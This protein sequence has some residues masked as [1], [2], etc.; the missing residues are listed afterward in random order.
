M[1]NVLFKTSLLLTLCGASVYLNCE[2]D[3]NWV[4]VSPARNV[5]FEPDLLHLDTAFVGGSPAE[6]VAG[7]RDTYPKEGGVVYDSL[8]GNCPGDVSWE[9]S[10]GIIPDG[11]TLPITFRFRP[12]SPLDPTT[13]RLRFF[14]AGALTDFGVILEIR[15]AAEE[16]ACSLTPG[17]ELNFGDV[18]VGTESSL[19]LNLQ[20][21]TSRPTDANRL[22]YEFGAASGDCGP[23]PLNPSDSV[24]VIGPDETKSI[25]FVFS[26]SGLE[27]FECRRPLISR[28]V[29]DDP[30]LDEL[31]QPCPGEII[32]RGSGTRP[33]FYWESCPPG[34]NIDWYGVHGLSASEVYVAG[35]GGSVLVSGGDCQWSPVSPFIIDVNLKGIWGSGA[36][37]QKALWSVG[38]IP[39]PQGTFVQSGAILRWANGSWTKV[40]EGLMD[41]YWSVWGSGPDDVYF[42]GLGV[43]TD[44]PNAKHWIGSGDTL[45]VLTISDLGMS[46]VSGLSGTGPNDVWAV[47]E[48]T[49]YSVYRF[50]GGEGW[51]NQTQAFVN[52]AL[53]DVWAI[54][55]DAFYAVYAVG[56]E[57]SVYRYYGEGA[58]PEPIWSDESIP[59]ETRD[60]FGVWIS[61]TGQVFVVGEG[62]VIYRGHVNDPGN[63]T[64]NTAPPDLTAG[65]L[66]DVW[67][68]GDGD[69]YAVGTNGVIIRY[70]PAG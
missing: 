58:N 18:D 23:F 46:K 8:S 14:G 37:D 57:G 70:T 69:V 6:G 9:P 52:Q 21:I 42:G 25:Q 56:N 66:M 1:R 24:G 38:T 12:R 60:F 27:D 62:Q 7:L 47:L 40:D 36:G 67:G 11:G 33:P 35:N 32:F 20:N 15:L 28:R 34:S 26:P 68:S 55:T 54:Q 22:A 39:P 53:H 10:S 3:D 31:A 49:F 17:T 44:F 61:A 29:T 5:R 63:W 16:P 41:G 30:N 65:D 4:R 48:Q 50:Q 59:G 43:S 13:C 2:C 19:P 51:E 64:L 45:Q